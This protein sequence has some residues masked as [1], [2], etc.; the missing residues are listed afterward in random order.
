MSKVSLSAKIIACFVVILLVAVVS[1]VISVI[2]AQVSRARI[3]DVANVNVPL[4][5]YTAHAMDNITSMVLSVRTYNTSGNQQDYDD[6]TRFYNTAKEQFAGIHS[7]IDQRDT[8]RAAQEREK[9]TT[10]ET[11]TE[12]YAQTARRTKEIVDEL[13]ALDLAIRDS[14]A[15][16]KEGLIF[17][18]N[19]NVGMHR[20]NDT[21]FR[22][23]ASSIA[24]LLTDVLM[25]NE[26]ALGIMEL[27]IAKRDATV[28]AAITP[29]FEKMTEEIIQLGTTVST[30]FGI[31]MHADNQANYEKMVADSNRAMELLTELSGLNA[32]RLPL[33]ATMTTGVADVSNMALESTMEAA[34]TLNANL[35]RSAFISIALTIVMLVVGVLAIL[36]INVA[37]IS[38][39][40]HFV[41]VMADFTSGDGDLTKRVP[42]TSED[43]IGQLGHHVNTFVENIQEIISRVKETSDNVASGNTELAATVEELSTTFNLQSEQVSGVASNMGV[44]NDVSQGIVNTVQHGSATMSEANSAVERGNT[45]LQSVMNTMES[46]KSQTTELSG[47]IKNLSESSVKIGEILTVISGIADQTNLL[48]LN[49]AIEAARAGEAGRGFAVVADEVRKLAEGTQSS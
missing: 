49:A 14:S 7:L 15:K 22:A 9:L 3:V 18:S 26:T 13:T 32:Q 29:V 48:A 45:E 42:I 41:E 37:I 4:S 2:S 34:N 21:N 1:S 46:I 25:S 35:T 31:G 19:D 40:R 30:P 28:V 12:A 43:E 20:L 27:A 8:P 6:G 38:K 10:L 39:L 11:A 24:K 47:T 44:M 16:L 23:A 17:W 5:T 36:F 33:A